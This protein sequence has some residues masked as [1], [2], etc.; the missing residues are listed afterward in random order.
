MI[1]VAFCYRYVEVLILVERSP[2]PRVLLTSSLGFAVVDVPGSA[3]G[4]KLLRSPCYIVLVLVHR[5]GRGLLRSSCSI[6]VVL[7][8]AVMLVKVVL[9]VV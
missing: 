9:V 8:L 7:V 6:V 2:R 3:V 1:A 4:H 5:G